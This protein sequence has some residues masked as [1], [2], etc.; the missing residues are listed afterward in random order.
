MRCCGSVV[1]AITAAGAVPVLHSCGPD[2]PVDL[3]RGLGFSAISFD[4]ALTRASD[5]W[6]EA[7]DAGVDLWFGRRPVDRRRRSTATRSWTRI[8][9]FFGHFGFDEEAYAR[10]GSS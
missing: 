5:V 7:F 1:D 10:T 3:L 9:T 8:E 6:A 2:V 4:L